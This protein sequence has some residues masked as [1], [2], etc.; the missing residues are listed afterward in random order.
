MCI[1]IQIK[2]KTAVVLFTLGA[3]ALGTWLGH[4]AIQTNVAEKA[5]IEYV[6]CDIIMS[7]PSLE[8]GIESWHNNWNYVFANETYS[9]TDET[10][11][12]AVTHTC[13]L[14]I[15]NPYTVTPCVKDKVFLTTLY[16]V[17]GW[18][19]GL[20]ILGIMWVC[21]EKP[22]KHVIHLGD[23]QISDIGARV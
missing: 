19:V 6:E 2:F 17:A 15:D 11:N 10:P 22:Q 5:S 21:R 16:L 13:C 14:S 8:N 9:F 1:S 12:K 3:L 7:L 23:Q 20:C 4:R 18:F